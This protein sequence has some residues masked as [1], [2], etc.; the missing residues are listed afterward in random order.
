MTDAL[1]KASPAPP[2]PAARV[3][4]S[5]LVL[6]FNE[7][8]NVRE[9]L[10]S[11]AW[12]DER[13]VV[14]SCSTD[15]TVELARELGARVVQRPWNGINEQRAFALTE[16][17]HEWVFC[18]D[19]DERVTPELA[20]E[21]RRVLEA[22]ADRDGYEIPRRTWYLGRWIAHGG[23]YPDR[24]LRLF[25]KTKGRFGGHDPHDRFLLASE[26]GR[27]QGEIVHF[28]YRSFS[29]QLRTIDRFSDVAARAW[30]AQGQRPGLLKLLVRPAWKFVETYVLKLGFLDGLPGF[31]ISVS[32]SFYLFAK[33]VKLWEAAGRFSAAPPKEPPR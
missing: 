4:V 11:L 16:S 13:I 22:G 8:E 19:A 10:E 25:R 26:P 18:L 28:T 27:L 23:W 30:A 24:K 14:D 7:E 1:P 2:V 15:R 5:A 33:Y 9:C 20:A 6:T 12:A 29:Q 21:L 31:I 17:V 3:P 32:T